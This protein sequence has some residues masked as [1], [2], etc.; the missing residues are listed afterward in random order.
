MLD[1]RHIA[2]A[3]GRQPILADVTFTVK[4]GET[5]ALVGANGAG[6]TTLMRIL[7]GLLVPLAG[8]VQADGIDIAR[9]PM[10]YCRSLGY[11]PERA[12]V[13]EDMCVADYL[14]FRAKIKGEKFRKIRHRVAEALDACALAPLARARLA[15]LSHGQRRRVALADALL[16]R[17][18]F[19]LA[20][21]VFGGIDPMTRVQLGRTL[22]A[23]APFTSIVVSGH[24]LDEFAAFATRFAVLR[25]GRIED[26]PN[27]AAVRALLAS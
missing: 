26:A 13:A 12:P 7:A 1:V 19:L 15:M 11:L 23:F 16:L 5:V 17:P 21:D 3:Y 20:D 24:E 8:D 27:P 25:D 14:R 4:S 10:R 9:D 2:F 22:A 6:K 18:R